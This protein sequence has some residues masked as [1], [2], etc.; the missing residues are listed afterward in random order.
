MK[1][2]KNLF[3][4]EEPNPLFVLAAPSSLIRL[5]VESS[6]KDL[7]FHE[8]SANCHISCLLAL[9]SGNPSLIRLPRMREKIKTF[10][11]LSLSMSDNLL[12]IF[13][14]STKRYIGQFNH[15]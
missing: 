9:Q 11:R 4:S 5:E 15:L 6:T 2:K 13:I 8:L 14:M 10:I 12:K 7:R 1:K 3:C